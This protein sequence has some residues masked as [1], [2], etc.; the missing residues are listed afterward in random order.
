M[1]EQ[2]KSM[3]VCVC[4]YVCADMNIDPQG[5]KR[6]ITTRA[7]K[8]RRVRDG[9]W[10]TLHLVKIALDRRGEKDVA[11]ASENMHYVEKCKQGAG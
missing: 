4:V 6:S 2:R 1:F 10:P 5:V 7:I 3:F 11:R 9:T 8:H